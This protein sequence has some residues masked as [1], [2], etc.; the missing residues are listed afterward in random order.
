M[1]LF[2]SFLFK[3]INR[4]SITFQ[5]QRFITF[6]EIFFEVTA[7]SDRRRLRDKRKSES[8]KRG[9]IIQEVRNTLL[10]FNNIRTL[11]KVDASSGPFITFAVNTFL[12]FTLDF[13]F[14]AGNKELV[15][16]LQFN[17]YSGDNAESGIK[18][19]LKSFFN[20][21]VA[22]KGGDVLG[23]YSFAKNASIL[24]GDLANS[25]VIGVHVNVDVRFGF[26]L[27]NLFNKTAVSRLPSPFLKLYT[28]DMDG[29]MGTN[30]WST[31][32]NMQR[33]DVAI[34]EARAL[35]SIQAN[36][37]SGGPLW[38]T[39]D[40]DFLSAIS[41]SNDSG[42][43]VMASLDVSMPIFVLFQGLGYGASLQYEDSNILDNVTQKPSFVADVLIDIDM[44]KQAAMQLK[45][46]TAFL[47]G[48]EPFHQKI[49]LLQ[50]SMNRLI[51]G[52][53]RT[54][55][56]MFDLTNFADN[57]IGAPTPSQPAPTDDE[58]ILMTELI[59]QIRT[60]FQGLVK[61]DTSLKLVPAVPD[62]KTFNVIR[63]IDAICKGSDRAIS[64][65][66]V[67]DG[68][69]SLNLTICAL[70]EFEL[71]GKYDATGLLSAVE[72]NF[73]VDLTGS[74]KLMGS[75][76]FGAKLAV[77]KSGGVIS[78]GINFDPISTELF[79]LSDL[80]ARVSFGMVEA[81]GQG[82]V[83]F[84]GESSLSYCPGCNG[85]HPQVSFQP[86]SNTSFYFRR[87]VG[88]DINTL[89]ALSDGVPGLEIDTDLALSLSDDNVFD[90]KPPV[91]TPP[92]I[93]ALRDLIKF[94]P[95]NALVMLRLIDGEY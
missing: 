75:L 43:R 7:S 58:Y 71:T 37:T 33:Y 28:F 77:E 55:A 32:L 3:H 60:A 70:L 82:Q 36:I 67:R 20:N 27:N 65:D 49:P 22:D 21:T 35:V 52:N 50:V 26:D 53:E 62:V 41:P 61:P 56:D 80:G 59:S 42:I 89:I 23:G 12:N 54:L 63:P 94:S 11:S 88:Y 45:R 6:T 17:F 1:N 14:G 18:N 87:L 72:E 8:V 57:L 44:I 51:A 92:D 81:R 46:S 64:I 38:L 29:V 48:Y 30:E 73:D 76:M 24:A 19:M 68:L 39:S 93:Q 34:S 86:V 10:P 90:A 4:C 2:N 84:V 78:I 95:E 74:F 16:G 31:T 79:V 91:I 25:L 5:A 13:N 47:K 15:F 9:I 40:R 69:S 85:T 83:N 66:I